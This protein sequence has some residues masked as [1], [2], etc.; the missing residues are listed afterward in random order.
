MANCGALR[1]ADEGDLDSTHPVSILM[2]EHEIIL[3]NLRELRDIA[4]QVK[5]ARGFEELGGQL[6]RLKAIARLLLDTESHHK[7]EEE[8]IFP[9]M[10][11]HGMMGPPQ[12]MR[13]EHEEL[14]ARK[15]T[16][17]GLVEQPGSTGFAEFAVPVSE[18]GDYIASALTDHI[19]KEDNILYPMALEALEPEEWDKVRE[20][21]DQI[22]YCPFT[23]GKTSSPQA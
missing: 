23:P 13:M 10:E 18:V 9:R 16:L 8:A 22:G 3:G 6:E 20:E 14:R 7:R 11:Q 12:V 17:A 5:S 21:F 4:A 2:R 19:F 1:R 15:R